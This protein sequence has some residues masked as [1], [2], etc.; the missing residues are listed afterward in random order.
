MGLFEVNKPYA[1]RWWKEAQYL[2]GV[3][4]R[5]WSREYVNQ[6]NSQQKWQRPRCSL[7]VRDIVLI[8]DQQLPRGQWP[9]GVIQ[10]VTVEHDGLPQSAAVRTARSTLFAILCI[11]DRCSHVRCT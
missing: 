7:A 11:F 5:R 6:L 9:L 2:I 1:K 10:D 8:D 3:F 4:W